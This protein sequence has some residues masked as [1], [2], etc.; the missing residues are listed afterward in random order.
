MKQKK[1]KQ[2]LSRLMEIAGQKKGLLFVAGLLSAGSAVC[3]LIPYWAVYEILRELLAN[4]GNPQT[5]DGAGMI[6]WGWTTSIALCRTDGI[7]R[8]GLPH[9][10]W[11]ARAF[12]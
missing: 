3:M 11:I 12:V 9:P 5:A 4:G 2:G 6:R 1:K 10:L 7:A 8:G